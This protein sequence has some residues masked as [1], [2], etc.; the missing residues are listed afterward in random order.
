MYNPIHDEADEILQKAP[1]DGQYPYYITATLER[2]L[3]KERQRKASL[4]ENQIL[5]NP[6]SSTF[7]LQERDIVRT[8]KNAGLT[9]R[10]ME[11]F[12]AR[13]TGDSWVEIGNRHGHT[14]QG[15]LQIFKQAM[16]KIRRAIRMN[17]FRGLHKV[18][19][20]EV[21]R[22]APSRIGKGK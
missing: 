6:Q 20:E 19:R 14:K 2:R 13:V 7:Y 5:E 4:D 3:R 18:Y 17:P 22:F 15:A 21:T 8:I 16:K 11:V 9:L 10:Q 12:L 1:R